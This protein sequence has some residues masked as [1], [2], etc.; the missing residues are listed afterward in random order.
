MTSRWSAAAIQW[1][2]CLEGWDLAPA[3][4]TYMHSQVTSWTYS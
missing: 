2:S 3:R 1:F 4:P